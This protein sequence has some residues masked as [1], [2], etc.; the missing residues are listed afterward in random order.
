MTYIL[1]WLEEFLP[2]QDAGRLHIA[3]A[4]WMIRPTWYPADSREE[5]MVYSPAF[6]Q[7]NLDRLH[8]IYAR[9]VNTSGF[10]DEWTVITIGQAPQPPP[11]DP[12]QDQYLEQPTI[13]L[14]QTLTDREETAA[15]ARMFPW[16]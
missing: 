8:R 9:W 12:D 6:L 13:Y 16:V 15:L 4:S 3:W 10:A 1:W 2:E 7:H 5:W 14:L 11:Q